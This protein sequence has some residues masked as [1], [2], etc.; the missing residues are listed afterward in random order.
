MIKDPRSTKYIYNIQ[1]TAPPSEMDKGR[2]IV[3]GSDKRRNLKLGYSNDNS[4]INSNGSLKV[5]SNNNDVEV[6]N[7]HM[8]KSEAILKN[9]NYLQ[10]IDS[11]GKGFNWNNNVFTSNNGLTIKNNN[12]INIDSSLRFLGGKSIYNP[13]NINTQMPDDNGIN[14]IG[15]DTNI[16]GSLN[17]LGDNKIRGTIQMDGGISFKGANNVSNRSII[18][19]NENPVVIQPTQFPNKDGYNF[20][21]GDTNIDGDSVIFGNSIV[22]KN[23]KSY[24]NITAPSLNTDKAIF[25][26]IA[27]ADYS[28]FGG[29]TSS[30]SIS[31]PGGRSIYN[32]TSENTMFPSDKDKLNYIRGDTNILG[33]ITTPG[34]MSLNNLDVVGKTKIESSLDVRGD[35]NITG[36]LTATNNILVPN[37]I[38]VMWSGSIRN[39]PSGWALCD[40]K[41]GTPDLQNRFIM[42]SVSDLNTGQ[43]G[44][45]SSVTLQTGNIPSHKHHYSTTFNF[46]GMVQNSNKLS[47]SVIPNGG[48][49]WLGLP[50]NGGGIKIDDYTDNTGSGIPFDIIPLYYKLAFI[51]KIQ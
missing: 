18:S 39:I 17:V 22:N 24:G 32:P 27:V 14:N 16:Y 5:V 40:G 51:M 3:I 1:I 36:K 42:G 41:N 8:N 35:V 47:Q 4:W 12:P 50:Y 38:I 34:N 15:G 48:D 9:T 19:E 28:S 20:I 30:K 13:N 45:S 26:E 11:E 7:L 21:S 25:S 10:M 29:F 31:V 43:I 6:G 44:G 46:T 2:H 37:G 33:N 49:G 23:I